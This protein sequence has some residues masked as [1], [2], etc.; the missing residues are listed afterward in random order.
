M[1]ER[2]VRQLVTN[3]KCQRL[4]MAGRNAAVN[5]VIREDHDVLLAVPYGR[6]I[7]DIGL[8]NVDIHLFVELKPSSEVLHATVDL[9]KLGFTHANTGAVQQ[10]GSFLMEISC[11]ERVQEQ[12]NQ[13]NPVG[14]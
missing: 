11:E 8:D 3:D 5:E 4:R 7:F 12:H 13:K 10:G 9:R 1:I 14:E 2:D 6:S